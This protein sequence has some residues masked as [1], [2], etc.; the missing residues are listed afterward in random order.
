MEEHAESSKSQVPNPKEIPSPKSQVPLFQVG[1]T[2]YNA[3]TPDVRG[4]VLRI[5]L[6]PNGYVYHVIWSEAIDKDT[7]HYAIELSRE[8]L[9][10]TPTR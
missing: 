4:M 6:N 9:F 10:I 7:A 3:L 1:E 2:V 8:P 5:E